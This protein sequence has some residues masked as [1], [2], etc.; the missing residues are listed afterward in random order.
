MSQRIGGWVVAATATHA[1]ATATKAAP[2][3]TRKQHVVSALHLS[4]S[5]TAAAPV[6]AQITDGTNVLW[7]GYVLQNQ[8]FTFP[9]G[10]CVTPGSQVIATLADG[11]VGV[12]GK[13]NLHGHTR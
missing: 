9:D 10:L 1:T 8:P 3:D 5:A 4:F 7:E 13:V 12:V 11:G 6:L 2:A